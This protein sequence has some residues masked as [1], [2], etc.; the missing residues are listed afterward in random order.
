MCESTAGAGG[1]QWGVVWGDGDRGSGRAGERGRRTRTALWLLFGVLEIRC[2]V[3]SKEVHNLT[4]VFKEL[5][6]LLC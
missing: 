5:L 1:S 4:L 2:R 3:L 6:L